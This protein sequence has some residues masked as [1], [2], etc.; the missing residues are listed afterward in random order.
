MKNAAVL[1]EN[2]SPEEMREVRAAGPGGVLSQAA[3]K[4]L[5]RVAGGPGMGH[6]YYVSDGAVEA[7]GTP[8]FVLHR[9]VAAAIFEQSE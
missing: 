8:E 9:D 6:G 2:L 5:D 7:D 3:L 4:A 1:M